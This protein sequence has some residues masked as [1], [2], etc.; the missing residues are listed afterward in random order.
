K[1]KLQAEE[2]VELTPRT[3]REYPVENKPK[4]LKKKTP[5]TFD[6][7]MTE[8][9]NDYHSTTPPDDVDKLIE[10]IMSGK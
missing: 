2:E 7:V 6:S 8:Y 5:A 1:F 3:E 10:L 9:T 4:P